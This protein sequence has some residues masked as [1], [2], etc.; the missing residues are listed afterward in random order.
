MR[1][2][3]GFARR[4]GRIFA[5]SPTTKHEALLREPFGGSF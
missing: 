1:T 2:G 3:F 5:E 4:H